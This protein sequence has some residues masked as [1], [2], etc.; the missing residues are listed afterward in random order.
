[1]KKIISLLSIF[2][3]VLLLTSC[4]GISDVKTISISKGPDEYYLK[5]DSVLASQFEVV[6]KSDSIGELKLKFDSD[7]VTVYG[8]VETDATKYLDTTSAGKK[9]VT[10][11]YQDVSVS[12]SYVVV[13]ADV[14]VYDEET[15]KNEI[16]TATTNKTIA[17]GSNIAMASNQLIIAA[18]QVITLELNGHVLSSIHEESSGSQF[19]DVKSGGSLT[20]KDWTDV[21]KDGTGKGKIS[22]HAT[23]PDDRYV[24]DPTFPFPYYGNYTILN[25]GNL[26]VESG[27]IENTTDRSGAPYAINNSNPGTTTIKGG[28]ISQP[29][30]YAI[31]LLAGSTSD[32]STVIV[33]GGIIEGTRA[34]WVHLPGS[35][36]ADSKKALVNVSGGTLTSL[37]TQHNEA[38]FTY[39]YGDNYGQTIINISGGVFNGV[40]GLNAQKTG[41]TV[42]LETL[43]ITGGT[44]N[45]QQAVVSHGADLSNFGS[46]IKG[47]TYKFDPTPFVDTM[48][49]NI[50]LTNGNYV[51][52]AK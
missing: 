36:S 51:V 1:M 49:Y 19:I 34:I 4:F 44:F 15:L 32:V 11:H 25:A 28:K 3:I 47:G 48:T 8:L 46:F 10:I 35:N 45:K 33:Q 23:N 6:V 42:G 21:K 40:I 52:T 14:L 30:N 5:G 13:E 31:R 27:L 20:I 16:T 2:V 7:N 50:T 39:S 18:N 29:Y 22:F 26:I 9:T 24:N 12:V 43:N 38:I 17:L 37:N 41:Y